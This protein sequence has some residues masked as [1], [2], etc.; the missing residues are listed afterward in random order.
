[1]KCQNFSFVQNFTA[2]LSLISE[3]VVHL[4]VRVC[5]CH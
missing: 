5:V 2:R 4:C 1:M 3:L